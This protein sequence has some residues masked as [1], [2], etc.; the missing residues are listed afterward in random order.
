MH[1]ILKE[2]LRN[3]KRHRGNAQWQEPERE[4]AQGEVRGFKWSFPNGRGLTLLLQPSG[5]IQVTR[6]GPDLPEEERRKFLLASNELEKM[7]V[8]YQWAAGAS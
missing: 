1:A 7:R 6:T 3:L 5:E 2:I 4:P 8:L